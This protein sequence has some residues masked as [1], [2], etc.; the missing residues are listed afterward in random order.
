MLSHGQFAVEKD[1][2]VMHNIRGRDHIRSG[3]AL[4]LVIV[5]TSSG[6]GGLIAVAY[7]AIG[8]TLRMR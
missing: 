8:K 1:A 2:E 5:A 4:F 6:V 7:Q 3:A